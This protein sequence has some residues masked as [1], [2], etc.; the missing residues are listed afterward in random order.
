MWS[1]F[2]PGIDDVDNGTTSILS[3]DIEL[4][5]DQTLTLSLKYYF[6]HAKNSSTADYLRIMVIGS[7]TSVVLEELGARNN[8]NAAWSTF[9]IDLSEFA[10]ETINLFIEVADNGPE[11]LIEAAID[12]VLIKAE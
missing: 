2:N 8:D 6:A 12:D 5:S 9:S 7:R 3:P 10:G 4:P 11:S 1:L